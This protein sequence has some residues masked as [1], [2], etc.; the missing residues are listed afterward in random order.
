MARLHAS[1]DVGMDLAFVCRKRVVKRRINAWFLKLWAEWVEKAASIDVSNFFKIKY[2]LE[3]QLKVQTLVLGAL[4]GLST[5]QS[6][7]NIFIT[8]STFPG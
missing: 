1:G 8:Y 7:V 6:G 3:Y 5:A 4:S 2:V